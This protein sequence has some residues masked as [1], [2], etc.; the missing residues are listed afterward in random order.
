MLTSTT[1]LQLQTIRISEDLC[2]FASAQLAALG[3]A[4]GRAATLGRP[5]HWTGLFG[6]TYTPGASWAGNSKLFKNQVHS[7]CVGCCHTRTVGG[8]ILARA[9]RFPGSA[10]VPRWQQG[11]QGLCVI[12]CRRLSGC[13]N[14]SH[15]QNWQGFNATETTTPSLQTPP[16]QQECRDPMGVGSLHPPSS[17]PPASASLG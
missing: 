4:A 2:F 6:L 15:R 12:Q 5:F 16:P 3:R 9:H 14:G 8:I 7:E 11:Q 13:G 17:H 1:D 10:T